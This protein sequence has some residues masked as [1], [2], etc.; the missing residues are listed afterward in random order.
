[1]MTPGSPTVSKADSL[2]PT[3][4]WLDDQDGS[5][6]CGHSSAVSPTGAGGY[7]GA[8]GTGRN[9]GCLL[10]A[11]R[12]QT[13]CAPA[14]TTRNK[15]VQNS[16]WGTQEPSSFCTATLHSLKTLKSHMD[17]KQEVM[18]RQGVQETRRGNLH[19]PLPS[20]RWHLDSWCPL[21]GSHG[22]PRARCP[23]GPGDSEQRG[24][25]RLCLT[26]SPPGGARAH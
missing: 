8:D 4:H 26:L 23:Q 17:M 10:L 25:G 3:L 12:G 9:G 6:H 20:A 18:Q 11:K 16:A 15:R 21:L 7:W 14:A 5:H 2:T 19:V 22:S 1:M 24:P 13:T